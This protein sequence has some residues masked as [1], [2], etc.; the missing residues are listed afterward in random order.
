MPQCF[1]LSHM[2]VYFVPSYL[3]HEYNRGQRTVRSLLGRFKSFNKQFEEVHSTQSQWSIPDDEL[4]A[5]LRLAIAEIPVPAY[6]SFI[7]RFGYAN[8]QKKILLYHLQ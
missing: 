3:I 1:I 8:L 7:N 4:R 6:R 5:D 2:V